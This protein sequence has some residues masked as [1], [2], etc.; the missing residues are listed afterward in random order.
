MFYKLDQ[1]FMLQ[2]VEK[3]SDIQVQNPAYFL[4]HYSY[5]QR[6]Q[7]ILLIA[8]GPE[9]VT[10]VFK[11]LF[12]YLVEDFSHRSLHDFIL[13]RRDPQWPLLAIGFWY[14]DPQRRLRPVCS[15]MDS[16]MQV[17]Q[18]RL[19]VLSIFLL[20]HPIHSGGRLFVQAVIAFPE[21]VDAYMVQ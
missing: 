11:I 12:P 9:S 10:E 13:Q 17:A 2:F 21:Q 8:S 5:P 3:G 7:S 1:P 20:C 16:P 14:E 19:Q 4:A 15:T 6:I 18:S